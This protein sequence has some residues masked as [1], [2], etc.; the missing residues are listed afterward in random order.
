M[1]T[2]RSGHSWID[3]FINTSNYVYMINSWK[4]KYQVQGIIILKLNSVEQIVFKKKTKQTVVLLY[5]FIIE[6]G[7]LILVALS[8]LQV[9]PLVLFFSLIMCEAMFSY[10]FLIFD[11]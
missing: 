4:W 1:Q 7:L 6:K 9:Y 2:C 5:I 10:T 8:A 3:A 11:I